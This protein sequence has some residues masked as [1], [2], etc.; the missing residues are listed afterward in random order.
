[1]LLPT[2]SST[3]AAGAM[4]TSVKV[5]RASARRFVINCVAPRSIRMDGR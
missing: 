3:T 5:A 2:R 1:M 4:V